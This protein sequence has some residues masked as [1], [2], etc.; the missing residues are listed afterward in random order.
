M[1]SDS[2]P[3]LN[4]PT[5]LDPKQA[6]FLDGMRHAIEIS[7]LSYR[8]LCHELTELAVKQ[9]DGFESSK[10][11]HIFLDAWAFID[12]VDRFRLL[13][14]MQPNPECIPKEYSRDAV[15]SRMQSIRDVRNVSAHI[16][17]KIDQIVALN[18]SVLGSINWVTL[19]SQDPL[20]IKTYFIRP[21]VMSGSVKGQFAMPSGKVDFIEGSGCVSLAVGKHQ[22]S[23]SDAYRTLCSIVEFAEAG[24]TF[25][26][27]GSEHIQHLP[28]DMFGS[29]ELNMG[30]R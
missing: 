20:K 10:F 21:G 28:G 12:A 5:A 16:A 26:T 24:M 29:A 11:T 13:W 14:E 27:Q 25:S 1:L 3:F 23:L 7:D 6:V 15:R 30:G 8:R 2:S 17:Q 22:V 4:L 18:S 19:F 9:S